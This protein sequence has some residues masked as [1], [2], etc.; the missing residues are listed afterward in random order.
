MQVQEKHLQVS[1][2]NV[3][4]CSG[5]GHDAVA[6]A[7]RLLE[8][9]DTVHGAVGGL[10]S[11]VAMSTHAHVRSVKIVSMLLAFALPPT[12]IPAN[13]THMHMGVLDFT[14]DFR[15]ACLQTPLCHFQHAYQGGFGKIH[16]MT[17]CDSA[18]QDAARAWLT[19]S[20]GVVHDAAHVMALNVP[21]GVHFFHT[22]VQRRKYKL[23]QTK[24]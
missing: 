1:T 21:T 18:S 14:E 8:P 19:A 6:S 3:V 5:L 13:T 12:L 7:T 2:G 16:F 17:K 24:Q 11:F 23:G 20:L 4:S 15:S 9:T 10:T 22:G